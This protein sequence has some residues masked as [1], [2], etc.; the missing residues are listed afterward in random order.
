MQETY[1]GIDIS[2]KTFDTALLVNNS[3][4]CESFSNELEGFNKL[5]HWL[6]QVDCKPHIC[7]EAIGQCPERKC[8]VSKRMML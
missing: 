2:K 6:E 1:L 5:S 7:L 4:K 3:I 8:R